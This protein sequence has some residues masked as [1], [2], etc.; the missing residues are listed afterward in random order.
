MDYILNSSKIPDVTL[1]GALTYIAN[2]PFVCVKV[3]DRAGQVVAVSS[4]G[5][6]LLDTDIDSM[7][8]KVWTDFW[9]GRYQDDAISAVNAAFSGRL[10]QFTGTFHGTP[11][12]T[13]WHIEAMPLE[14]RGQSVETIVVISR[15]L[16]NTDDTS[17]LSA[18]KTGL[19]ELMHKMANIS[20]AAQS[21]GRL[22]QGDLPKET[23]TEIAH[24]LIEV[25]SEGAEALAGYRKLLDRGANETSAKH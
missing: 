15:Y 1:R 10:G 5:L 18:Q 6:H 23:V 3:L 4:M 9:T 24:A 19:V 11:Q 25:G 12:P 21:A 20:M 13:D 17:D 14:R 7:L 2:Q 16:A 22:L 8:G